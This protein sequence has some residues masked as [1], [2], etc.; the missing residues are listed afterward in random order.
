[1]K[2]YTERERKRL[3]GKHEA[4]SGSAAAFCRKHGVSAG[5]LALWRRRYQ[6]AAESLKGE[7]GRGSWLPVVLEPVGRGAG[8]VQRYV[9]E[10][11]AGARMEVPGRFNLDEVR[12][13]WNLVNG[14]GGSES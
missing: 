5:S 8:E 10:S 13:L 3:V 6:A 2:R 7:S 1:M 11:T 14:P 12:T 9:L 4:W